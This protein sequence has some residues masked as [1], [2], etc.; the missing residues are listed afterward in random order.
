[1]SAAVQAEDAG[2]AQAAHEEKERAAFE[3]WHAESRVQPLTRYGWGYSNAKT[4][5]RW[6]GWIAH[7]YKDQP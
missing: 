6:E 3:A 1:M 2:L 4:S 5:A 7:S